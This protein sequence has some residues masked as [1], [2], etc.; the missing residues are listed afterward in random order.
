MSILWHCRKVRSLESLSVLIGL[1]MILSKF[2]SLAQELW[3]IRFPTKT[4][5]VETQY[6]VKCKLLEGAS[7][8]YLAQF[9]GL[10]KYCQM[11]FFYE[12]GFCVIRILITCKWLCQ[13][14]GPFVGRMK[15]SKTKRLCECIYSQIT[16]FAPP[17]FCTYN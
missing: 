17:I 6:M 12:Y 14:F 1:R 13:L 8:S 7:I 15:F 11:F 16:Y 2:I 9:I 10:Q 4:A 5:L 3:I